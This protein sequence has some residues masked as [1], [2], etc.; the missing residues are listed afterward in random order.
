MVDALFV[1]AL[2][3]K[4]AVVAAAADLRVTLAEKPGPRGRTIDLTF[5]AYALLERVPSDADLHL[6]KESAWVLSCRGMVRPDQLDQQQTLG[7]IDN[8]HQ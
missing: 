3:L 2:R 1:R 6:Y 8:G 5:A 7:G 4:I